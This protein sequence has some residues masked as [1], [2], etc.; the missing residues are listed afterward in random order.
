MADFSGRFSSLHF[1]YN[2]RSRLVTSARDSVRSI[3]VVARSLRSRCASESNDEGTFY[4][5]ALWHKDKEFFL[6]LVAINQI[7]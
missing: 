6:S 2:G 5:Q 3:G 1:Y 4:D 7:E